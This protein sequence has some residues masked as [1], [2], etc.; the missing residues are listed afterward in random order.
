MKI[1]AFFEQYRKKEQME[2]GV[3]AMDSGGIS[4]RGSAWLLYR[5]C[6]IGYNNIMDHEDETLKGRKIGWIC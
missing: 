3:G 1:W 4:P 6:R 2:R 5:S